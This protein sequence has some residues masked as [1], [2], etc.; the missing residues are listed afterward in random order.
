MPMS[1]DTMEN[2]LLVLVPRMLQGG[3][4]DSSE[5]PV[6]STVMADWTV[7]KSMFVLPPAVRIVQFVTLHSKDRGLYSA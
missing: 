5:M 4:P 6:D 2:A 1:P 3:M 7:P